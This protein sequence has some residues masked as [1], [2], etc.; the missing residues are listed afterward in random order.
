MTFGEIVHEIISLAILHL[1]LIQERQ[2]PVSGESKL[3]LALVI[4]LGG[5]SLPRNNVSTANFLNIWTPQK[6]VVITLKFD[7][8]GSAIE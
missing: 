5:L 6:F 1:P 7:F 8:C 3:H 2:L 4:H